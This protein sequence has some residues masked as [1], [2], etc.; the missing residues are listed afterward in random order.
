MISSPLKPSRSPRSLG[1][2][3]QRPVPSA[4][5]ARVLAE[6]VLEAVAQERREALL[7]VGADPGERDD[8]VDERARQRE[9]VE[10]GV[11][12]REVA[13]VAHRLRHARHERRLRGLPVLKESGLAPRRH[14][15]R[16]A[17]ACGVQ[18]QAM[19]REKGRVVARRDRI[20]VSELDAVGVAHR[21]RIA[22]SGA[23]RRPLTTAA[24]ATF[25]PPGAPTSRRIRPSP[26]RGEPRL[27]SAF[28][29]KRAYPWAPARCSQ[30]TSYERVD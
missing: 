2:P 13:D 18:Q 26:S 27:T 16:Q 15:H 24:E 9:A 21:Q 30:W 5:G 22:R 8:V 3:E 17:L 23:A 14:A 11:R 28:A 25:Q 20:A 29:W 1:I 10:P 6:Q 4:P 7:R 12:R 19:R